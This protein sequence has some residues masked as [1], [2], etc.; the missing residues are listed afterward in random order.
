[1]RRFLSLPAC[2]IAMGEAGGAGGLDGPAGCAADGTS[3]AYSGVMIFVTAD[4]TCVSTAAGWA[5]RDASLALEQ[6]PLELWVDGEL[7]SWGPCNDEHTYFIEL[8]NAFGLTDGSQVKVAGVAA[9]TVTDLNVNS[10]K[11]AVLEVTLSGPVSTLGEDT[12]C[13]SE[14]QSLIAEYFVDCTPKGPPRSASMGR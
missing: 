11:R 12:I 6:D 1:M 3:H 7:R 14:P 8:D 2:L 9:G 10:R 4:A 5:S 13:R